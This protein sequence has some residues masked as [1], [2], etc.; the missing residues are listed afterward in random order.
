MAGKY[1][2]KISIERNIRPCSELAVPRNSSEAAAFGEFEA[3][4]AEPA[5]NYAK[6]PLKI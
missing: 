3:R 1:S 6:I 4:G 5:S 2:I